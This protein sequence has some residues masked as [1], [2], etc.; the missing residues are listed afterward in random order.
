MR[1]I[2]WCY[3]HH[4]ALQVIESVS[5]PTLLSAVWDLSFNLW[6]FHST[7]CKHKGIGEVCLRGIDTCVYN[8]PI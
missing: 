1:S 4:L 5:T 7:Q 3:F 2:D 8:N 6:V